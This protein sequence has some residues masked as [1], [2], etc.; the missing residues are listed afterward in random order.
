VVALRR[1]EYVERVARVKH[2]N[3]TG[4]VK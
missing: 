1:L 4:D 2:R 3:K